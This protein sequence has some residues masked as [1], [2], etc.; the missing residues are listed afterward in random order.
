MEIPLK[1]IKPKDKSKISEEGADEYTAYIVERIDL[2]DGTTVYGPDGKVA[3]L[4]DEL[5]F[6]ILSE[7]MIWPRLCPTS[8]LHI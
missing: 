6:E 3:K 5:R 1:D 8:K 7:I 4:G 2:A